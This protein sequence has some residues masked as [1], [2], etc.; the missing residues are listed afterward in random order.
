MS[1]YVYLLV[2]TDLRANGYPSVA[3]AVEK[4]LA[5]K[6]AGPAVVLVETRKGCGMFEDTPRYQV[7]LHGE[8]WGELYFNMTGYTGCSLP[9]PPRPDPWR[10]S[11]IGRLH[12]GERSIALWKREVARVNREW[13]WSAFTY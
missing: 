3:D 11:S 5:K 4:K 1:K 12:V 10:G 2:K 13:Q 8:P 9:L 6:P 7:L